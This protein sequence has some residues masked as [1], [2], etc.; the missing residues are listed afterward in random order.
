MKKILLLLLVCTV[1]IGCSCSDQ[2]TKTVA[3]KE[4]AIEY[5]Y[6]YKYFWLRQGTSINTTNYKA[7]GLHD[8]ARVHL[9]AGISRIEK[10]MGTMIKFVE[11]ND[12]AH[13]DFVVAGV[14]LQER[15]VLAFWHGSRKLICVNTNS[16]GGNLGVTLAHELGH[17]LSLKHSNDP[18]S[19]MYWASSDKVQIFT[20]EDRDNIRKILEGRSL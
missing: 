13:A 15:G 18:N 3:V 2:P 20:K 6:E 17:M 5:T 16:Y 4:R 8:S 7:E 12:I 11:V 14:H 9:A 19:V 1:L 10:A